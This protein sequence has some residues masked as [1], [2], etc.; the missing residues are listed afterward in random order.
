MVREL[1]KE[2]DI[3]RSYYD[4]MV[5]DAID[6]IAKYGDFEW[7]VSDEPY[8]TKEH[9]IPP[10]ELPCGNRDCVDCE[11]LEKTQEVDGKLTCKAGYECLIF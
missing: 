11:H 1:A 8:V 5:N 7:F 9:D 6:T 4:K 10:W 3:D 2:D